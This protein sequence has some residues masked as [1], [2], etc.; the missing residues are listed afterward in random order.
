MRRMKEA[1]E[2]AEAASKYTTLSC[3]ILGSS[4]HTPSSCR[5]T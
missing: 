4:V 2:E 3:L 1:V 5:H